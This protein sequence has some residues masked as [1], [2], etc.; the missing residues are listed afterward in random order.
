M[1]KVSIKI[2]IAGRSYPLTVNEEEEVLVQK[3]VNDINSNIQKLQENYAVKDMQDLLAMTSLQLAT[4]SNNT[5]T[6]VTTVAGGL[7]K[8][9]V[10][11]A[12]QN[13][14]ESLDS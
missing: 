11:K 2:V 9:D 3:A 4:R 5:K 13:L 6:S 10:L 12:L 8:A 1:G 7:D 14:S